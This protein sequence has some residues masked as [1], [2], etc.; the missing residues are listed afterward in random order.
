MGG[1][2]DRWAKRAA[3]A[4]PIDVS[5]P[6]ATPSNG[7][8]AQS[9]PS[10]R[11]DFLKKAGI[12]GGVAW[13]IPVMQTVAAPMASASPGSGIGQP[14]TAPADEGQPCGDGSIC[15]NGICGSPGAPCGAACQFGNCAGGIC[16]GLGATCSGTT[17]TQCAAVPDGQVFCSGTSCGGAG[18]FCPGGKNVCNGGNCTGTPK[19][20]T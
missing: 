16:G 10:S 20:C 12:V 14:C 18:A 13:S 15:H 5:A 7:A 3:T 9:S 17:S 11:R 8:V 4:A 2:L 19:K 1:W 6:E